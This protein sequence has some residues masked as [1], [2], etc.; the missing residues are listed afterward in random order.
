M[1]LS[2]TNDNAGKADIIRT[3]RVV[4]ISLEVVFGGFFV[5]TKLILPSIIKDIAIARISGDFLATYAASVI[6]DLLLAVNGIIAFQND[7][8]WLMPPITA[9]IYRLSSVGLA[10]TLGKSFDAYGVGFGS[11]IAAWSS[12]LVSQ[13]WFCQTKYTDIKLWNLLNTADI[14][15][16]MKEF[17][18]KGLKLGL[19][20]ITEWGNLAAISFIIGSFTNQLSET[21]P[22]IETLVLVNSFFQGLS[23]AS[24]FVASENKHMLDTAITGEMSRSFHKVNLIQ[25]AV[26]TGSIN[27]DDCIVKRKINIEVLSKYQFYNSVNF[28]KLPE[29]FLLREFLESFN[30][31]LGELV[32]LE[33][34]YHEDK[35]YI[36]KSIIAAIIL[37]CMIAGI[38]Y[39]ARQIIVDYYS[40]ADSDANNKNMAEKLLLINTIGI[41]PDG[42]RI[43]SG[44]ILRGCGNLLMPNIVSLVVMSGIGI[45]VGAAIGLSIEESI[46]PIFIVR[47]VAVFVAASINCYQIWRQFQNEHRIKYQVA[48]SKLMDMTMNKQYQL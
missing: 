47:N 41:I 16:R 8:S 24:M 13:L 15:V 21:Q 10:Y 38:I 1:Q 26:L 44:S 11:S 17:G 35:I 31:P 2:K 40:P 20:G 29:Q 48:K 4:A 33:N 6:P 18:K 42:V 36:Y 9:A 43:V 27:E 28:T 37:N 7:K 5:S 3:T 32:S 23:R 46:I 19:G 45:P 39:A 14:K 25:L 30:H 12:M 34:A 22:S